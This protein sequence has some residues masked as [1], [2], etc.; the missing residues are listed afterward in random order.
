MKYIYIEV[1]KYINELLLQFNDAIGHSYDEITCSRGFVQSLQNVNA[2]RDR[3]E[4][5]CLI[6]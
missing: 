4:T 3:N 5:S 2:I 6:F 1:K